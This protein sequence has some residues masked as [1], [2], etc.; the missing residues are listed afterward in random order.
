MKYMQVC[1]LYKI[2]YLKTLSIRFINEEKEEMCTDFLILLGI[3]Y[4]RTFPYKV[5]K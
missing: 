3:N 2:L 4:L 5:K 1:C